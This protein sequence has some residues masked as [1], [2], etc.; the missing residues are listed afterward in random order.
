MKSQPIL[1]VDD[2]ESNLRLMEAILSCE[3]YEVKSARDAEEAL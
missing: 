2:N 1:I 3:N